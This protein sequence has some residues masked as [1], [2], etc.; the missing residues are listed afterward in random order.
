MYLQ[1]KRVL[2]FAVLV[3]SHA[4]VSPGQ[5]ATVGFAEGCLDARNLRHYGNETREEMKKVTG[6]RKKWMTAR[7]AMLLGIFIL[8]GFTRLWKLTDLP[9]GLHIDEAAMTYDA[10]CLSQYGVNRSLQPWP[11]YLPNFWGGQSALYTYLCALLFRIFGYSKWLIRLPAVLVSLLNL[12]FGMKLTARLYPKKPYLPVAVGG[13]LVICPYF[14]MASRFG[15]DCNLMLGMS[16]FF[17][18]CFVTAVESGKTG[19]YV[20]AGTAGGLLLYAYALTYLIVPIF[21]LLAFVYLLWTKRFSLK[22]WVAMAVPMG[23]LALPLILV[24]IVNLF[25]LEEF[26]LGCFTIAKMEMNR[27]LEIGRFRRVLLRQALHSIFVGDAFVYNSVPG[28]ATVY[29]MTRVF[30]CIG[31]GEALVRLWNS[32]RRRE[33]S[34]IVIVLLWLMDMLYLLGH[35]TTNVNKV[36][37]IFFAVIL[38]AAEGVADVI[39]ACRWIM[40]KA[41]SGFGRRQ[42]V[43]GA[44]A[45]GLKAV[46]A[47][48]YLLC[49]AR[50]AN[51][52]FGGTYMAQ[53]YMIPLFY[54]PVPEAIEFIEN[55]PVLA[56]K[57]TYSTEAQLLYALS[58]LESPYV[59]RLDDWGE[60]RYENYHFDA[61]YVEIEDKYNYIVRDEIGDYCDE[62]RAAGFSEERYEGYSLFYKK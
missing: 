47:G 44:A 21:L 55:D 61:F 26:Q 39:H 16:T 9:Y 18:Y 29:R 14:I 11:V 17:L 32:V 53:N 19:R 37:A 1:K 45:L 35:I 27:A 5:T 6:E 42:A 22:G 8:F 3:R 30:F 48:A 40:G 56:R 54:M 41:L 2:A 33:Q 34:G 20:L 51:Y 50:F 58:T 12:L 28:Y 46:A 23:I 24:Q 15:L 7:N 13:L 43:L 4:N 25:D 31:L 59:L 52:Y 10:W 36:N 49:F 60:E 62:L 38:L 57:E